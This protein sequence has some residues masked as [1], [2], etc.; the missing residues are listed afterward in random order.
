MN[1]AF[2]LIETLVALT[3]LVIIFG[4]GIASFRQAAQR[5]SLNAAQNKVIGALTQAQSNVAAGVRDTT[6]CGANSLTGWQITFTSNSYTLEG[7]CGTITFPSPPPTYTFAPSITVST[8]PT[9][10]PILFKTL[11][12]GTNVPVSTTITLTGSGTSRNIRVNNVGQIS[13]F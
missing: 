3:A 6:T 1:K 2:T 8:L 11:R 13:T 4:A 9:P 12:T 10:N 5:Q 7:V